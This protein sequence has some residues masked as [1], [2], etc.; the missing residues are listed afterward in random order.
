MLPDF[1]DLFPIR[2]GE[3]YSFAFLFNGSMSKLNDANGLFDKVL[4]LVYTLE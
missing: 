2:R 4:K 1:L 3:T